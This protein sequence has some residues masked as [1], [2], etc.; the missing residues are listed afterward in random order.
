MGVAPGAG[1]VVG[2][3]GGET[4]NVRDTLAQSW[5]KKESAVDPYTVNN[6]YIVD[7]TYKDTLFCPSLIGTLQF[8]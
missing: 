8:T 4:G 5:R 2:R 3:E 1:G 6:P 7:T